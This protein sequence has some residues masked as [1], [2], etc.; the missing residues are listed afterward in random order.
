MMLYQDLFTCISSSKN[1]IKGVLIVYCSVTAIHL[2]TAF[3]SISS[4]E[5]Q[6]H[7]KGADGLLPFI[8]ITDNVSLILEVLH[9]FILLVYTLAQKKK[10]FPR[11]NRSASKVCT[12]KTLPAT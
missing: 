1:P 12:E 11:G 10:L 3:T 8:L 7:K 4:S 2:H 5:Q 6:S 9:E